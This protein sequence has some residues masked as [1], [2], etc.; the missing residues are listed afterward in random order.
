VAGHARDRYRRIATETQYLLREMQHAEGGFF[1]SQD[2]DSEGVE[3]KFFAWPWDEL[4]AIVGDDVARALGA[5]PQGN[6]E[7]TNVL[8][9]PRP[10][11]EVAAELG[12]DRL[13]L[14]QDVRTARAELFEIREGRVHPATDDKIL[15]GWNGLAISALAEAGRRWRACVDA[16]TRAAGFVLTHLRD[17]TGRLLRSWRNG[18][19][20]G[21]DTRRP[22][23]DGRGLP[24]AVRDDVR[25]CWFE[26]ARALA[27]ELLRRFHDDDRGGFFQT[28]SDAESLIVR[29]KELYDNAVPSGNSVAADVLQ[30]LAHLTGE[31]AFDR[32]GVSALRLVRDGMASAPTAFGRALSALDLHLSPVKEV[33]IVGGLDA[34]ATRALVDEVTVKHSFRTTCSP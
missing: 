34:E 21:P 7:G 18:R 25:A 19:A 30:R 6:W 11:V 16:A 4:V 33:A 26:E 23:A 29:P 32:A 5:A 12:L 28:G 8:W 24:H 3:G 17:D 9:T 1:S 10:V 15:A 13:E 22:R 2:A 20:D 14:E 31:P 27:D